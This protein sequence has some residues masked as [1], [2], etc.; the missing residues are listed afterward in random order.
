MISSQTP[1]RFTKIDDLIRHEHRFLVESDD[2]S[3][4]GEYTA[5]AGY[6]HSE[7]NDKILSLKTKPEAI[8]RNPYRRKYKL[9]AIAYWAERLA[10]ALPP[11]EARRACWIPIPG[12]CPI[13]HPDHDDRLLRVLRRAYGDDLAIASKLLVQDGERVAAHDAAERP[14]PDQLVEQ[15]IV[16]VSE[17]PPDAGHFIVFDDVISRGASFKAAQRI[18]WDRL[19]N[20]TVAGVFLARTVHDDPPLPTF[21]FFESS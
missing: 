2:C 16:D 4:L 13:G 5:R 7:T 18:V 9:Q 10:A 15:W 1:V 20:A 17:L 6:S 19:S 11:S 3:F 12:S 8:R 14:T 21:E